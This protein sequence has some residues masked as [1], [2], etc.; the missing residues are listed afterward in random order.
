MDLDPN[1][2]NLADRLLRETTALAQG[3]Q[4]GVPL[5][6]ESPQ[7]HKVRAVVLDMKAQLEAELKR[8]QADLKGTLDKLKQS[9]ED[10][11][12]AAAAPPPPSMRLDDLEVGQI[13]L[14]FKMSHSPAAEKM[15]GV[16]A[17]L[18]KLAKE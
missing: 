14:T 12:K 4:P 11:A 2:A 6:V 8:Q 10:Q 9:Q 17:E 18:L 5:A 13:T 7:G 15:H 1:L 16:V 3:Q